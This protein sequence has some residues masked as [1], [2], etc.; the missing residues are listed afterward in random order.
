[1]SSLVLL[2]LSSAARSKSEFE[3]LGD[4]LI[5]KIRLKLGTGAETIRF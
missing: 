4:Y 3:K 1:L 2:L 5:D